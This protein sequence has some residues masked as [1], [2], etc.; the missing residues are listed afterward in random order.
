MRILGWATAAALMAASCPAWAYEN[1]CPYAGQDQEKIAAVLRIDYAQVP[2]LAAHFCANVGRKAYNKLG[3]REGRK[4][5][6]GPIL[7]VAWIN[8]GD[9]I[10]PPGDPVRRAPFSG[11]M[12]IIGGGGIADHEFLR[13]SSDIAGR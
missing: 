5:F 4:V 3:P 13:W 2:K 12:Y 11:F 7:G 9:T 6:L 10:T 8:V 1:I